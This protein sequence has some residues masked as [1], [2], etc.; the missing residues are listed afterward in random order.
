VR[1]LGRLAPEAGVSRKLL[2]QAAR[3]GE[4]PVVVLGRARRLYSTAEVVAAFLTPKPLSV[5]N[6]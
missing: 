4:L 2:F 1:P 5:P 3:A 6:P